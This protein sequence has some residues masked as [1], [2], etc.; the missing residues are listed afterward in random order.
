MSVISSL[1]VVL[2][3]TT[4]PLQKGFKKAETLTKEF[5]GKVSTFLAGP[6]GIGGAI[7]GALAGVTVAAAFKYAV[8]KFQEVEDASN[9]LN[10]VLKASGGVAGVTTS[11]VVGL[12]NQ[13]SQVTR[14]STAATTEAAAAVARFSQIRGPNFQETIKQAQNFATFMGKDL[15]GASTELAHALSNPTQGYLELAK[16]GVAFSESQ[17]DA[18]Q[19][20]QEGGDV[21]GAQKVILE[22][23]AA[24]YGDAAVAA[25]QTLGGSI[26]ILF[27]SMANVAAIIGEAVAPALSGAVSI[28]SEWVQGLDNAQTKS[29][30]FEYTAKAAGY[31]A[32]TIQV[33]GIAW[34]GL[35]IV[36]DA[37][38]WGIVK[39]LEKTLKAVR[40]VGQSIGELAS[41]FGIA[42]EGSESMFDSWI[43]ELEDFGAA[44]EQ[45][46]ADDVESFQKKW[47]EPW[48]HTKTD[49]F[50]ANI[51]QQSTSAAQEMKKS[52]E[53]GPIAA[54]KQ[55]TE[56]E[57]EAQSEATKLIRDL[58]MQLDSFGLD[59]WQKKT[60]ELQKKGATGG[61]VE[62][63]KKLSAQL[64]GK[65]LAQ[66]L[67]TPFEKFE[68]EVR[69][70]DDLRS[71]GG[72]NDETYARAKMKL[73]SELQ[74]AQ[75]TDN[76]AAGGALKAN[77]QEA[78]SALLA[79]QG[80]SRGSDPAL[81]QVKLQE[82]LAEESKQ[83]T[84][85]LRKLANAKSPIAAAPAA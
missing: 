84:V 63:F 37:V 26:D 65:E 17:I 38:I 35:Q 25:G 64:K 42:S 71:A 67:E 59:D 31:L 61:Q 7:A 14:F 82:R 22:A 78:R 83:Q 62:Q 32:D 1:N 3:A 72:I 45:V 16:A 39:G 40:W 69:K 80:L 12:A 41:Y 76:V 57:I 52:I 21:A 4:G 48:D 13:L 30:V 11:Q 2:S 49:N 19:R 44:V 9:R 29:T 58:Q 8:G 55:L 74:R 18:I 36:A 79:F 54:M 23:L 73:T 66:S 85:Y 60:N 53:K 50:F 56:K 28:I 34:K 77:S 5:G 68:R 47:N 81:Q 33:L 15:A 24:Q 20:L 46:A 6:G 51:K 75:S 27:N 43:K 10:S 70:L